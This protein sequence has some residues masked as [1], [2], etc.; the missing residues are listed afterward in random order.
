MNRKPSDSKPSELILRDK[1]KDSMP[2]Y[3]DVPDVIFMKNLRVK[4]TE[5]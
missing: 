3:P 2:Q 1:R 5:L 4:D